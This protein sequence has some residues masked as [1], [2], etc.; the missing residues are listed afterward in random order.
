MGRITSDVPVSIWINISASIT[1]GLLTGTFRWSLSSLRRIL[2]EGR[3][4]VKVGW[5]ALIL[6]SA[7]LILAYVGQ[8]RMLAPC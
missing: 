4:P 7:H 6:E 2:I 8:Q 3:R 1:T 5:L